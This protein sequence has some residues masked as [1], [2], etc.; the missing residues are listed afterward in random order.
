VFKEGVG[1][2]A[3]SGALD[4][5]GSHIQDLGLDG[6]DLTLPPLCYYSEPGQTLTFALVSSGYSLVSG[7]ATSVVHLSDVKERGLDPRVTRNVRKASQAGV[8]V[9]TGNDLP[10]FHQVLTRNLA[11]KD[12]TPTHSLEELSRLFDLFPERVKLFEACMSGEVVGG[13]LLMLCNQVTALAFYICA[14]PGRRDVPIAEAALDSCVEFLAE[15]GFR[16]FDLGTVSIGGRVNWGLMQFKSKFSRR[17]YVRERYSLRFAE[18][19]S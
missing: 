5:V 12:A 7:E 14:D 2:R 8:K 15:S 17:L 6:I 18:G 10:A 4:L 1:L 13:C 9:R 19:E 16:Y 3:M 11:A